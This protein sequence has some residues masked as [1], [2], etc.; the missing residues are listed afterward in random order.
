VDHISMVVFMVKY[1]YYGRTAKRTP[2]QMLN[3]GVCQFC[4]PLNHNRSGT[5]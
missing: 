2:F 3:T 4:D 5:P 1:C